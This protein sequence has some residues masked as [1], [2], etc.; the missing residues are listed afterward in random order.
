MFGKDTSCVLADLVTRGSDRLSGIVRPSVIRIMRDY[1][2]GQM[3]PFVRSYCRRVCCLLRSCP[4]VLDVWQNFGV[5]SANNVK[6][7]DL[8]VR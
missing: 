8:G 2:L 1:N 5:V 6:Y 3:P 7:V 4:W